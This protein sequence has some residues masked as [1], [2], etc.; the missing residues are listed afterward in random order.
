MTLSLEELDSHLFECVDIIRD[1]VDVTDYKEY[2]LPLVYFKTI[3][4]EF[5]KQYE[6][7]VKEYSAEVAQNPNIYDIPI[8]SEGHRWTDIREVSEGVGRAL[9]DALAQLTE[10]NEE[11]GE[12]FQTDFVEP[13][14]LDDDR[15]GH[16]VEHLS[17]YDLDR[18]NVP[19]DIL[20]EA[21]RNLIRRI[22]QE[23]GRKGGIFYTPPQ[24]S[25]LC[26]RLLGD[27]ESDDEFHDPTVGTAG[28]LIQAANY[29]RDSQS[30]DASKLRLTGQEIN[31]DIAAIAR[32]NL[33]IHALNGQIER[34]DSLLNPQFTDG[35]ELE[36]FDYVLSNFPFSLH[37]PKDKIQNDPFDRFDWDEKLPRADRGDYAFIM[38]IAKQLK[39]PNKDGTGGK[40]A[41]VIPHGVLFRNYDQRY[42]EHML[43]H[44]MVE[45]IIG[46][47][48]NLFQQMAIPSAILVLNTDKPP[49]R[50]EE[51]Q[52]IH[53]ADPDFYQESLNQNHLTDEG[54]ET[55]V[56]HVEDWTTEE[57]VSKTATVDEIRSNDYNLNISLYVEGVE[58]K[59]GQPPNRGLTELD[60]VS[61]EG[62]ISLKD[63]S[64][65]DAILGKVIQQVDD[66]VL[67]LGS[68][69]GANETELIDVKEELQDLGYEAHLFKDL[70]DFPGQ[71]LSGSVATAMRLV[72]FCVMVDRE[73]SGHIDEYRLAEKQRT[74]LARLVPENGGST[75]GSEHVDVNYIKSFEFDLRPQER[76]ED[77]TEWAEEI[78]DKRK[79]VYSDE[80]EWRD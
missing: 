1:A 56:E 3:S 61:Y 5:E 49:E 62:E 14:A 79:E 21:F 54:I 47:P 74:I 75:R 31:P 19:P 22:A 35:T 69:E 60:E 37:W 58:Y 41:I 29:Y 76:I 26:V 30:G 40:A 13:E 53:A 11:L 38:H 78:I 12:A 20:G 50:S 25:E 46:L 70:P 48:E 66:T 72:G 8:V 17:E 33:S 23:E 51:V 57:G 28:M 44:D 67:V 59:Q 63:K 52:F 45:A 64:T 9:N 32:L 39:R 77:A 27:F 18:E 80:Y 4:D 55:I 43:D 65:F 10:E 36:R 15:L 7:N 16:L 34:G 71:N 24:I 42:R 68:Y 2:I 6:Q 73:A